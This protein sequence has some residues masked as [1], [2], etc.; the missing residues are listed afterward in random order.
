MSTWDFVKEIVKE[1]FRWNWNEPTRFKPVR[2]EIE[3]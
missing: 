2:I 1:L 3:E